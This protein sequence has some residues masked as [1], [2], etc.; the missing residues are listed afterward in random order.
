MLF[1]LQ[2]T[3]I[4]NYSYTHPILFINKCNFLSTTY[5]CDRNNYCSYLVSF[6]LRLVILVFL[7]RPVY[8]VMHSIQLLLLRCPSSP[9]TWQTRLDTNLTLD[10]F[11]ILQRV[12]RH[13]QLEGYWFPIL[14]VC[15]SF[16]VCLSDGSF[17]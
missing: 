15:P 17:F 3:C 1:I 16:F 11:F 13:I 12:A 2:T 4:P 5:S 14:T 6:L 7:F 8:S 9:I 10:N